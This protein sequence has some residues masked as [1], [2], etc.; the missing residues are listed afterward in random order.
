M[1]DQAAGITGTLAAAG[2][3]ESAIHHW[4]HTCR[5]ELSGLTPAFWIDQLPSCAG[6]LLELARQDIADLPDGDQPMHP[7]EGAPTS[8]P[9]ES[10]S[11]LGGRAPTRPASPL[12]PDHAP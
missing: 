4:F 10:T 11:T 1:I 8:E 7:T 2:M 9:S 5:R 12:P 6:T 3:P